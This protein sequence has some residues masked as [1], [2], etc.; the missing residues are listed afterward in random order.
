[1]CV[2][3]LHLLLASTQLQTFQS[4]K[5]FRLSQTLLVCFTLKA[6]WVNVVVQMGR[7]LRLLE[8]KMCTHTHL[9]SW[10]L[11]GPYLTQIPDSSGCNMDNNRTTTTCLF[12][13][14][15]CQCKCSFIV[16]EVHV[17]W[18]IAA[19]ITAI[20]FTM[21]KHWTGLVCKKHIQSGRSPSNL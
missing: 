15:R 5:A 3:F 11:R 17:M 21:L 6:L 20:V 16:T 19:H 7:K 8:T 1:M 14:E 10:V 12:N 18:H 4:P 13:A 2:L 9:T